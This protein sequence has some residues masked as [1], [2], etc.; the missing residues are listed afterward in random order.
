MKEEIEFYKCSVCGNVVY[1]LNGDVNNIFCCGKHLEKIEPLLNDTAAEKHVPVY[2]IVDNQII[3]KVGEVNHPMEE[4][5]YIMWIVQVY[6]K[7]VNMVKLDPNSKPE[8][9]FMYIPGAILYAYCN[10]HSLWKTI[11][12]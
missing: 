10:K 12:K 11:V 4:E 3:V 7:T 5:H 6:D 9:K 8:A 1:L 2:E